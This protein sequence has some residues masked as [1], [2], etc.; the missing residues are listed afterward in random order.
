MLLGVEPEQG[1][2]TV[3]SKIG[4]PNQAVPELCHEATR[5]CQVSLLSRGSVA[6][7]LTSYRW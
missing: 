2:G 5:L 6:R 1:W 3:T 7:S 4:Q